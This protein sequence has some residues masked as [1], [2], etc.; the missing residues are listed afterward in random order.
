MQLRPL[1]YVDVA[2]SVER[3]TYNCVGAG[4]NPAVYI[5]FTV[6]FRFVMEYYFFEVISMTEDY[7]DEIDFLE[8][9]IK[10]KSFVRHSICELKQKA[11]ELGL[12]P[13]KSNI[14]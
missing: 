6:V 9:E 14:C 8:D 10:S 7:N 11:I 1:A 4:S 12:N 2:Q 5:H 13:K 3:A